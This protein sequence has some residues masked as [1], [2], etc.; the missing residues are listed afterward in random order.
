MREAAGVGEGP[1]ATW[2]YLE[3]RK[4][5]SPA[6]MILSLQGQTSTKM[7]D[8]SRSQKTWLVFHLLTLHAQI[9]WAAQGKLG[10]TNLRSSKRSILKLKQ[11]LR[12]ALSA[13]TCKACTY[14]LTFLMQPIMPFQMLSYLIILKWSSS[15]TLTSRWWVPQRILRCRTTPFKIEGS[16]S[17]ME[18]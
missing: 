1:E 5:R 16:I 9:S 17:G 11:T 6:G 10:F 14:Q 12:K 18:I 3:S 15:K 13:L 4:A 2:C 8:R 7:R